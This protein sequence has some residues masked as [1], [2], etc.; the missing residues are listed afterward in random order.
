MCGRRE[1]RVSEKKR[2]RF[3]GNPRLIK[4]AEKEAEKQ[5]KGSA[6]PS[7]PLSL[8]PPSSSLPP[9]SF[10]RGRARGW[11][12]R[13]GTRSAMVVPGVARPLGGA[14]QAPPGSRRT[15]ACV[16]EARMSRKPPAR[17]TAASVLL[18]PRSAALEPSQQ[19]RG[20][21]QQGKGAAGSRASPSAAVGVASNFEL[22]SSSLATATARPNR[23]QRLSSSPPPPPRSPRPPPRLSS[24]QQHLPAWL[25]SAVRR[26]VLSLEEAPLLVV[27]VGG[28]EEE[29]SWHSS[30]RPSSSQPS[31]SA[32]FVTH[33]LPRAAL[34]APA[35]WP[36][37]AATVVA[38]EGKE[39][40]ALLLVHKIEEEG[41]GEAAVS[42]LRSPSSPSSPSPRHSSHHLRLSDFAALERGGI[43]TAELA[44]RVGDC[45]HG[46]EGEGGAGEERGRGSESGFVDSD[47]QA[48]VSP[49][50]SSSPSLHSET[51]WGSL[52]SASSSSAPDVAFYGVVVQTA[53]GQQQQ[54]APS[55]SSSDADANAAAS[56]TAAGCF[57]LKTVRTRPSPGGCSCVYYSLTRVGRAGEPLA[58]QLKRSWLA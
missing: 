26:A 34:S 45:C 25:G 20:R 49:R 36:A 15:P 50:S 22:A 28:E 56:S 17:H 48:L 29:D 54:R 21:Q 35:L 58:E 42:S 7:R 19:P 12:A 40:E 14:M 38:P 30:R 8:R 3:P 27:K 5:S 53:K 47:L 2:E 31:T 13:N 23:R 46:G 41:E 18:S 16:V 52:P 10:S 44:G 33:A 11:L 57:V 51:H 9:A 55:F 4:F 1:V 43:A 39:P 32:S 37:I 24:P 6:L